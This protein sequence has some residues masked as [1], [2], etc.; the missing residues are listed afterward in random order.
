[1]RHINLPPALIQWT[2]I[3]LQDISAKILV[4]HT[5]TDR[6]PITTGIRQGC[7]LSMLLFSMATD[8]LSKKIS[9]SSSI[10]GLSLGSASIKLQQYADDTILFLTDP[11]EVNPD[12]NSFKISLLMPIC[13]SIVKRPQLCLRTSIFQMK[14][15]SIHRKLNTQTKQKYLAFDSL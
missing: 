3:L 12:C 13:E 11:S 7:P 9:S 4:N 10:K 8:V 2:T 6:I 14:L 5:L 15:K 1:M